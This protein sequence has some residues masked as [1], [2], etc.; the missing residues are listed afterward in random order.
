VVLAGGRALKGD[1]SEPRRLTRRRLR[2]SVELLL[3]LLDRRG[4][5]ACCVVRATPVERAAVACSHVGRGGACL[6][7]LATVVGSGRRPLRRRDGI[8]LGGLR[9]LGTRGVDIACP[10]L[11]EA[12]S[13]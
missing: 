13:V 2:R 1:A 6:V 4:L 10:R 12:A 8:V 7:R 5:R 3:L 11:A 9:R